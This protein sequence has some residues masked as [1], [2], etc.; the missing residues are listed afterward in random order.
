[1]TTGVDGFLL[2]A[3]PEGEPDAA[4]LFVAGEEVTG[5]AIAFLSPFTVDIPAP[6]LDVTDAPVVGFVT[7]F[8]LATIEGEGGVEVEP[9]VFADTAG[10]D[11]DD[12][13]I[14]VLAVIDEVIP[15]AVGTLEGEVVVKA[16]LD[17]GTALFTSTYKQ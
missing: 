4:A 5:V 16:I 2:V 1:M 13:V 9:L 8:T 7:P 14:A 15:P 3:T 10:D 11:D 17:R 12:D 6:A